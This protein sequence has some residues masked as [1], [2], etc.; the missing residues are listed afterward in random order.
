LPSEGNVTVENRF[1][2]GK[3]CIVVLLDS[4]EWGPEG[5]PL[6]LFTFGDTPTLEYAVK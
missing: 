6:L 5:G 1:A 2:E 4:D 3:P